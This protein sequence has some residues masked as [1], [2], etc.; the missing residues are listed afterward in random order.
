MAFRKKGNSEA[1][2][3][4]IP[5][6]GRAKIR[7]YKKPFNGLYHIALQAK[8]KGGNNEGEKAVGKNRG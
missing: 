8:S 3:R 1:N 5:T 7:G 4:G 2:K 6:A